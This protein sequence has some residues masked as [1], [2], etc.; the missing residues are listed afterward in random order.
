VDTKDIARFVVTTSFDKLPINVVAKAKMC[1]LDIIGGS[2]AAI[3]TKSAN[4]VRRVVQK[5]GGIKE[6]T[7]LGVGV[8]VPAPLA[9]WSNSIM[10]SA[11][12]IDDGSYAPTGH[13]GHHGA[14]M[15]PTGLSIAESKGSSGRNYIEAVVAGYEVGIRAGYIISSM[16]GGGAGGPMGSY[17]AAVVSAK[18]LQLN[19]EEIINALGIVNEHN[20]TGRVVTLPKGTLPRIKGMPKEKIGWSVL[21]GVVATLLAQEGF[22]GPNSIYDHQDVKQELLSSLG[23][24]YKI[25]EVYPKRYTCCRGMHPALDGLFELIGKHNLNAEDIMKVILEG[26]TFLAKVLVN[27]PPRSMEE[28]EFSTPFAI[29]AALAYGKVGPDQISEQSLGD[30]AILDQANK[31]EL[32]VHPEMEAAKQSGGYN[33]AIVKIKTKDGKTYKTRIENTRG[34]PKNPFTNDE[35]IDKFKSLTVRLLGKQGTD[36]VIKCVDNLE[37]LSDIKELVT[38]VSRI[39]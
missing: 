19:E 8:K 6:S 18:L 28:A 30:K 21:T 4:A 12:D 24:E 27:Y 23:K 16:P 36:A 34:N 7:L 31:V 14:L 13:A 37:N 38:L 1:T 33:Q 2:L 39:A 25:L 17:G 22:T 26:S 5:I 35:L 9:A 29:G 11:L 20:P 32:V 3:E 15:V 10:A